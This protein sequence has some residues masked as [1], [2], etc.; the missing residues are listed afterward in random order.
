MD[1]D[2]TFD[3]ASPL[4]KPTDPRASLNGRTPSFDLD[5]VYGAGPVGSPQ[6]YDP[7]D[8]AKLKVES[9]GLFEDVPRMADGTAI[10]GDPRNDEHVVIAG[11][12]AAF[13]M[14]HNNVVDYRFVHV[15]RCRAAG[16][17]VLRGPAADHL[18]LPVDDPPR[19]PAALR[20]AVD[21]ELDRA[22]RPALLP[23]ETGRGVHP[24]RVPGRRLPVRPLDGAA[25]VP[26]QSRR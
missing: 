20:R 15:E 11:M 18:A 4:G 10:I 8:R 26:G 14:V 7:A 2:M 25:V 21:G 16:R 24:G 3:T 22:P 12:Q 19:V 13:L 17:G 1:H 5:S 9:G 23:A 6:L